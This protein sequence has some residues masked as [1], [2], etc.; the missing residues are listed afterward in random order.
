MG[1]RIALYVLAASLF[2]AVPARADEA[3]PALSFKAV[4]SETQGRWQGN[5][6][7]REGRSDR[8]VN[9][10]ADMKISIADDGVT[11]IREMEYRRIPGSEADYVTSYELLDEDKVVIAYTELRAGME[12]IVGRQR[13]AQAQLFDLDNWLY[14]YFVTGTEGGRPVMKRVTVI[15]DEDIM[16]S[17]TEIDFT[18]DGSTDW[19]HSSRTDFT[20]VNDD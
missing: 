16:G 5:M 2:C 20:R 3:E 11:L 17:V 8:W 6:Q 10:P 18:D 4:L 19:Q 15:R 1:R 9:V 7:Y 13:I 12:P 14:V